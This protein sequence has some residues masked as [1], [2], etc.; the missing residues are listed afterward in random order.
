MNPGSNIAS[1][2]LDSWFMF[3]VLEMQDQ[4]ENIEHFSSRVVQAFIHQYVI[5]FSTTQ[6]QGVEKII[7]RKILFFPF[8]PYIIS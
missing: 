1:C 4:Q 3:G 5:F 6:V 2:S 8:C 7:Q